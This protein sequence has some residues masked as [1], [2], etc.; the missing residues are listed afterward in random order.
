MTAKRICLSGEVDG[1][2]VLYAVM[3]P[4]REILEVRSNLDVA[5]RRA[6]A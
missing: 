5:M 1:T 6:I 3:L 4:G 2:G